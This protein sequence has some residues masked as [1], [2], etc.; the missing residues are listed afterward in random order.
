[1]PT[2][3]LSP[4]DWVRIPSRT[5]HLSARQARTGR[6]ARLRTEVHG[7]PDTSPYHESPEL[8]VLPAP[9]RRTLVRVLPDPAA[10]V[11]PDGTTVT[12]RLRTEVPRGSRE[13]A[14]EV[15]VNAMD[16]S[17]LASR[18]LVVLTPDTDGPRLTVFAVSAV[19]DDPVDGFAARVRSGARVVLGRDELA[20]P[21]RVDLLIGVDT[22]ASMR[23]AL[24]D[25]SVAALVD[26]VVGLSYVVG[27]PGRVRAGLLGRR[28]SWLPELPGRE[29][30]GAVLAEIERVGLECGF[31]PS[32]APPPVPVGTGRPA[33]MFLVTDAVPADAGVLA[34]AGDR[35]GIALHVLVSGW[36]GTSGD[37]PAGVA[38]TVLEP[39]PP[40]TSAAQHLLQPSSAAAVES[41]VSSLV[42][43]WTAGS[44]GTDHRQGDPR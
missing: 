3:R 26:A 4:G 42:V 37:C 20:G 15:V 7:A 39:P 21:D 24:S 19:A 17:G 22:S 33:V 18:E 13:D 31:R 10:G 1:M 38:C 34:K 11:F 25:G 43:H 8:T 9:A 44:G 35:D 40:P 14:D 6:P 29:L 2:Y 5:L 12:L 28:P 23:P 30:S 36:P 16:V 32:A 27:R 41:F